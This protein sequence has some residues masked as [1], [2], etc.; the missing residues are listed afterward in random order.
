MPMV[1]GRFVLNL[2]DYWGMNHVFCVCKC[3]DLSSFGS[4]F[5]NMA[6]SLYESSYQLHIYHKSLRSVGSQDF[7]ILKFYQF[8]FYA[9]Q[10][11]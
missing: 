7:Q 4:F 5:A 3:G 11:G 9:F 6:V 10:K 8:R 1:F 2:C